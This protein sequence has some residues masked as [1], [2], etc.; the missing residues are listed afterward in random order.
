MNLSEELGK[1][2]IEEGDILTTK[3]ITKWMKPIDK[4]LMDGTLLDN[5]IQARK[6]RIKASQYSLYNENLYKRLF[7]HSWTKGVSSKEG[8][9]FGKFIMAYVVLMK[10]II[11]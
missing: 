5:K 11:L 4:Y 2:S 7:I 3:E 6:L 10:V 8:I 1:T 9:S